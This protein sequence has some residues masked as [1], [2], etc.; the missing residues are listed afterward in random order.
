M[1][2]L[3]SFTSGTGSHINARD[4]QTI[5]VGDLGDPEVVQKSEHL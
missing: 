1:H 2:F 3:N 4:I 5:Q